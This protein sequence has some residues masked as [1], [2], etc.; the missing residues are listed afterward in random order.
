MASDTLHS[1]D[2]PT[3]ELRFTWSNLGHGLHLPAEIIGSIIWFLQDDKGA[4][5]ACNLVS[6][7]WHAESEPRLFHTLFVKVTSNDVPTNETRWDRSAARSWSEFTSFLR[8]APSAA[9]AVRRL[10]ILGGTRQAEEIIPMVPFRDPMDF[11][12]GNFGGNTYRVRPV[13]WL[14]LDNEMVVSALAMLP[15]LAHLALRYTTLSRGPIAVQK[16]EE[17]F[18]VA[19][20]QFHLESL[21]AHLCGTNEDF[22]DNFAAFLRLFAGL[23]TLQIDT[24]KTA[25]PYSLPRVPVGWTAQSL[26]TRVRNLHIGSQ[27]SE[28]NHL[29]IAVLL[30]LAEP[31]V[32]LEIHTQ[33][34]SPPLYLYEPAA[35]NAGIQTHTRLLRMHEH[36]L[37]TLVVSPAELLYDQAR[38]RELGVAV[39]SCAKLQSLHV[40]LTVPTGISNHLFESFMDNLASPSITK[41]QLDFCP[42]QRY[43]P[44]GGHSLQEAL[45]RLP[46]LRKLTLGFSRFSNSVAEQLEN[47]LRTLLQQR[48]ERGGLDVEFVP[49][50]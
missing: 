11:N 5:A 28:L 40:H 12:R 29:A 17:N 31:I 42:D 25:G 39:S 33:K 3:P 45:A 36:A 10:T 32:S 19:Q 41:L 27:F 44:V 50:V 14:I 49:V 47:D 6:Y 18:P 7:S 21:Y 9:A 26:P 8:S 4:L 48:I 2:I 35:P 24:S 30:G 13:S 38:L 37:E 20:H 23:D 43:R 16:A 15:R 1:I 22:A 46:Q 34:S